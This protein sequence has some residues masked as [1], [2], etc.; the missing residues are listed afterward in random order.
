MG[1]RPQELEAMGAKGRA[2]V[3]ERYGWSVPAQRLLAA[4]ED[5]LT[6]K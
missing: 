2:L 6:T 4:Y 3:S 1:K 5:L